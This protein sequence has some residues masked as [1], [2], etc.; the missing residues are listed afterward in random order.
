MTLDLR[1][2]ADRG[3]KPAI[4]TPSVVLGGGVTELLPGPGLAGSELAGV[5]R[6]P[7]AVGVGDPDRRPRRPLRCG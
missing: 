7:P 6:A 3:F 5:A 2:R 4:D 1:R